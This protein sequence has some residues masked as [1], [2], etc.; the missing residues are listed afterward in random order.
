[1]SLAVL[2]VCKMFLEFAF[3]IRNELSVSVMLFSIPP[4]SFLKRG[5]MYLE[6]LAVKAVCLKNGL[7][8]TV[9]CSRGEM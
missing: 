5:V 4:H 9:R 2:I 8:G 6:A 1:M 3:C 7:E